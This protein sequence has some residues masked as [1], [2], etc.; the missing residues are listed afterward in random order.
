MM[1]IEHDWQHNGVNE[2][3]TTINQ[4]DNQPTR[5]TPEGSK[6]IGI[7]SHIQALSVVLAAEE[8]K[9][10]MQTYSFFVQ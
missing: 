5:R 7:V 1:L 3:K 2:K 4:P 6:S 10:L 8:L 9:H